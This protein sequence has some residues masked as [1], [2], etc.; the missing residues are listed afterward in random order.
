[1]AMVVF[2]CPSQSSDSLWIPAPQ[3]NV[4]IVPVYVVGVAGQLE[5]L[6]GPSVTS[7]I[8][9]Q[10]DAHRLS[11]IADTRDAVK[12]PHSRIVARCEQSPVSIYNTLPVI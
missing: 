6:A 10:T 7:N 5:K 3:L 2:A 4:S 11:S 1:M 9:R 12:V 8:H